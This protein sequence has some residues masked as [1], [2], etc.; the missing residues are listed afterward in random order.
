[1]A[2]SP[3]TESDIIDIVYAEYE[4]DNDT[5]D[6]SSSEYLTA[7][8]LSKAA[9]RRWEYLEGTKWPELFT[10][11]AG[12]ADGTLTTTA[13]TYTYTCPTNMRLPPTTDDYVRLIDSAG[14][15]SVYIIVP[16]TKVPQ[17][18]SSDEK[19]CYF[20]GNQTTGFTLNFNPRLT[21][22]TGETI[23]YEYYKRATYLTS[24]T[25]STEMSNPMYIVHY[26]LHRLYKSDGL[27]SESR[28][29]LQM[30]ENILQEM[31]SD[32][33][34]VDEDILDGINEGFGI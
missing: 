28:E 6:S 10:K 2:L 33:Q 15:A 17:L 25:S 11:T 20:T 4:N 23:A 16:L 5:W 3:M 8:A 26:I 19:F 7:R 13:G 9:I 34:A 32:V 30:A 1:M 31:R 18:N 21:L 29:E 12:A 24:T 22:T 27:L 14:Q